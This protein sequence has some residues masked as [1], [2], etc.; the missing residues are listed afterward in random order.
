MQ[1]S[2]ASR[3]FTTQVIVADHRRMGATISPL[4]YNL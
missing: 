3:K 2:S 4:N 1:L